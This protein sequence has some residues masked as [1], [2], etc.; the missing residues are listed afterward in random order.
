MEQFRACDL[1]VGSYAANEISPV[2][3]DD[4]EADEKV[5]FCLTASPRSSR[6]HVDA[7]GDGVGEHHDAALPEL[8]S[9]TA[10]EMVHRGGELLSRAL[11]ASKIR[12]NQTSAP[13][14]SCCVVHRGPAQQAQT[15]VDQC[16]RSDITPPAWVECLKKG[17]TPCATF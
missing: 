9:P 11:E 4:S 5:V 1:P 14:G 12:K 17:K 13:N 3:S 15:D 16:A 7:D 8:D 6:M 2:H 10:K